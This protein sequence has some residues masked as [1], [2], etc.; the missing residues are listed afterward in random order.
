M[1]PEE[2]EVYLASK[3][4]KVRFRNSTQRKAEWKKN[5][6]KKAKEAALKKKKKDEEDG[7]RTS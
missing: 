5:R 6:E 4:K 2:A 7:K 3:G 1:S